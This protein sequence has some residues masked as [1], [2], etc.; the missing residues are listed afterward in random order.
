MAEDVVDQAPAAPETF[1][2]LVQGKQLKLPKVLDGGIDLQRV[3]NEA[4]GKSKG[5]AKRQYSDELKE[6]RQALESKTMSI[7]EM[8]ARLTQLEDEKLSVE[9]KAKKEWERKLVSTTKELEL[10]R[11]AR[12]S[13]TQRLHDT[14]IESSLLSEI[15]KHDVANPRQL[16][17]L[18]RNEGQAKIVNQ[19]GVDKVAL[20]LHVNGE[21]AEL[22]PAEA[23]A[24]YLALP[25]NAHHLRN[26][27]RPGGGSSAAGGRLGSDGSL[28]YTGEQ[29]AR[30]PKARA[31]ALA[32]LKAGE[33]VSFD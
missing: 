6:L 25:E 4:I 27:L 12:A 24:K 17:I 1:D 31:E 3:I 5:D 18:L 10:E 9:E 28:N 32:K 21:V 20:A 23:V 15:S 30:D 16:M 19:N 29:L 2:F 26:N 33:S 11:Q 7:D 8:T 22:S 14:L 13:A